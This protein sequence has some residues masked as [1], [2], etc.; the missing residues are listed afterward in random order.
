MNW[1]VL[2]SF[3]YKMEHVKLYYS[4]PSFLIFYRVAHQITWLFY[5]FKLNTIC[6]LCYRCSY[7]TIHFN[8]VGFKNFKTKSV[9][10]RPNNTARGTHLLHLFLIIFS[11]LILTW[12]SF[13]RCFS[14]YWLLNYH[15]NP[16]WS[17][18]FLCFSLKVIKLDVMSSSVT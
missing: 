13:M 9:R 11:S 8:T 17:Q 10:S 16:F 14:S 6:K 15:K 4:H 7:F 3:F 1:D 5:A 2:L 18:Y 12:K